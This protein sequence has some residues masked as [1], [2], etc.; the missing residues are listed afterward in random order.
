MWIMGFRAIVFISIL[1]IQTDWLLGNIVEWP[2]QI[3]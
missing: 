3:G 2:W 1:M